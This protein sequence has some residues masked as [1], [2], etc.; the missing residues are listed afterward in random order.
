MFYAV[1]FNVMNSVMSG[2]AKAATALAAFAIG[3]S[4]AD[5]IAVPAGS[6]HQWLL[7]R[8]RDRKSFT[9]GLRVM[10]QLVLAVFLLLFL[11]GWTPLGGFVYHRVF[12]APL[13]LVGGISA[14][15]RVC[16]PLPLIFLLRGASQSI[17]M[18]KRRTHLMTAGVVVR[19]G[20]V[21][22]M[23]FLLRKW[24]GADGALLGGFLWISG[25]GIEG[26]FDFI[27][28]RRLFREYPA[29]PPSGELPSHGRIWRFLLP[30][31]ATSLLW[32]LGKPILNLGMARAADPEASIAVYQV[33][34]NAAWLL[35]AYVQGSFRHVII[36]FWNDRRT[37]HALQRF[38]M[39]LAASVTA[40]LAGLALTGGSDWFLRSVVGAPEELIAASRGVMLV[41]STFPLAL[42]A[43]E[44]CV[45]RL[46]RNGTTGP[47]GIAKGVNLLAMA[48]VAF[49]LA[50]WAPRA[51]AMIGALG[52]LA[53]VLGEF[54]IAYTAT[55]RLGAVPSP[56]DD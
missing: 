24:P 40:L 21:F 14:M 53:G 45:G 54:A 10:A 28:A 17:L 55:R 20:Y 18:V 13:H 7:A 51:G 49:G 29:M 11:V 15:V 9:V 52:A 1:I 12:G 31:I 50:A 46:L 25:M 43:T 44:V 27:V 39:I 19:L 33:A 16:L 36:V 23:S 38:A 5:I 22:A 26:L 42:M 6:G 3:Q 32:S 35:I 30:L 41:M 2:T 8:A 56:G 37:L 34:W 47:I 48:G 4:I